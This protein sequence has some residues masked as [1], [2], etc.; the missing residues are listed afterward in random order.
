MEGE[1]ST[2]SFFEI[3]DFCLIA[4]W[5]RSKLTQFYQSCVT[6]Q[7]SFSRHRVRLLSVSVAAGTAGWFHQIELPDNTW[8]PGD[9]HAKK[10]LDEK[11]SSS[12]PLILLTYF[13][14]FPHSGIFPVKH[15]YWMWETDTQTYRHGLYDQAFRDTEDSAKRPNASSGRRLD[16]GLIGLWS[17]N[18]LTSLQI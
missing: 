11:Q 17:S 12:Y 8:G 18:K 10:Q 6:Q 9:I 3:T 2:R 7:E 5:G 4:T 1:K 14:S 15:A 13:K 16:G